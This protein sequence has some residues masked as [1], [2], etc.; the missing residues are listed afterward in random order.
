MRYARKHKV[1]D[2]LEFGKEVADF[3]VKSEA[4]GK[5]AFADDNAEM[6]EFM[7][8]IPEIWDEEIKAARVRLA[9]ESR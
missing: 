1:P 8:V 7:R 5:K 6:N 3:Y 2:L 4:A 9:G